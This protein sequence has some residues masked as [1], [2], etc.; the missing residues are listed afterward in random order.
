MSGSLTLALPARAP[1]QVFTLTTH[2][3]LRLGNLVT[4]R[5]AQLRVRR[6]WRTTTPSG[7]HVFDLETLAQSQ[8]PAQGSARLTAE[9]APL[10][11][12]LVLE[13][14]A[15][16]RLVRVVNKPALRRQWADLLPQ[17]RAKY[18]RDPDIPP[19]LLAQLGQVLDGDDVLETTLVHSPEYGLLFPRLYGQPFSLAVPVAGAA[20]LPGF[21]GEIDLPLRTEALL[22]DGDAL[23]GMA[24]IVRV[25]GEVDGSRYPAAEARQVLCTLTDRP[26]LDT[27]LNALHHE[28]YTFGSH[29]ELLEATRY[30]RAE[31]PGV[32]GRQLIVLLHTRDQ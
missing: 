18:R 19:A 21:I 25:A 20:R 14:D 22:A 17:L 3:T 5:A 10:L 16:G 26:N 15:T 27:R 2:A 8:T 29:H 11:E 12:K 6:T 4:E 9:L 1:S 32:V 31:I 13:T 7:G 24:G 23:P 28:Q 30:T